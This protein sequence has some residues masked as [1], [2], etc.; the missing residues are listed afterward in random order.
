LSKCITLCPIGVVEE[1]ILSRIAEGIEHR[2]RVV[3]RLSTGMENPRY[4]YDKGRAQYNSKL[5]LKRLTGCCPLDSLGFMGVTQ[6]DLF[7]PILKYVFGLAEIKGPCAV[8]ST[9]R[10]RPEFYGEDP[11][12]GL[13]LERMEKTALHELGHCFG[14]SHCRD[15]RC[16]MYSST[17]IEHTDFKKCDFCPTCFELFRWYVEKS[18]NSDPT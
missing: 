14:I 7:V 2:C 17:G 8:I 4:A 6:V 3:C 9:H 5:I 11:N 10:L 15:R 1:D 16:V 12:P 18:V 13:L